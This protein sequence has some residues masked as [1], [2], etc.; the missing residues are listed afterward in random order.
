MT[1]EESGL[2]VTVD[3]SDGGLTP[4]LLTWSNSRERN[5]NLGRDIVCGRETRLLQRPVP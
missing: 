5:H 4:V 1:E 3:R 2:E